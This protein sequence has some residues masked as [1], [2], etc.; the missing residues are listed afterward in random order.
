MG[1]SRTATDRFKEYYSID[2]DFILSGSRF[3]RADVASENTWVCC[4]RENKGK[5]RISVIA[6]L[7]D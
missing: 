6:F 7:Q 1:A 5:V 3:H 4:N 2:D